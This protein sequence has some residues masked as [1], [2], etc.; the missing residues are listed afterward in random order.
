MH[1]I[2][3]SQKEEALKYLPEGTTCFLASF[4]GHNRF[5]VML[6]NRQIIARERSSLRAWNRAKEWVLEPENIQYSKIQISTKKE[7]YKKK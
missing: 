2:G 1:V 6:P 7:I 4:G 5:V 3:T